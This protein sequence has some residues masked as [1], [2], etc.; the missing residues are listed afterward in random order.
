MKFL[1]FDLYLTEANGF[2][3]AQWLE[4]SQLID[5][6]HAQW[7]QL[8]DFNHWAYPKPFVVFLTSC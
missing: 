5:F 4:I 1:I 7:S 6:G 3:N 8:T 2:G